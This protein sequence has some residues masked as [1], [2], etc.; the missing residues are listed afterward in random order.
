M[1]SSKFRL[2]LTAVVSSLLLSNLAW[3]AALAEG[4]EKTG[5]FANEILV[6]AAAP[7]TGQQK[8]RGSET[9]A[10][11]KLFFD[12]QNEQG[13]VLGRKIRMV[14]CDDKYSAEGA[15]QCFKA[16]IKDK[17]FLG[18]CFM[19]TAAA[20]ELVPLADSNQF[21]MVGF[22]TGGKFIVDPVHPYV[23]QLRPSYADEA[24][25]LVKGIWQKAGAQKVL[26]VYQRDAFGAACRAGIFRAREER[27]LTPA[28]AIAYE[29]LTED[30]APLMAQIKKENPDVVIIGGGGDMLVALTKALRAEKMPVATFSSSSDLLVQSLGKAADGTVITQG[31]PIVDNE[32]PS[33]ALYHKLCAQKHINASASGLE[34]FLMAYTVCEGLKRTGKDLTRSRFL[35]AMESMHGVD[36]GLGPRHKLNFSA[37][38]HAGL[39][40]IITWSVIRQGKLEPFS[41]WKQLKKS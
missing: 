4:E 8:I 12:Y 39:R 28:V 29:R 7:L 26:V 23:F 11:G 34:G 5:V 1:V 22:S 38:N 33:V 41:D 31:L 21:P 17:C 20:S 18:T 19:G 13:G 37:N 16:N 3:S 40:G 2:V 32:L 6:G 27:K 14:T 9:I 10:G 24:E 25:E 36:I 35:K 15:A 30:V